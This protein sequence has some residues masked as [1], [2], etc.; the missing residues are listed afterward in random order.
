MDA[1]ELESPNLMGHSIRGWTGLES[2]DPEPR[3]GQPDENGKPDGF[4]P[5]R[6]TAKSTQIEISRYGRRTMAKIKH[7]A[8]RTPDP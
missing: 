4:G 3:A 1:L 6:L 7:I 8:I 5:L 2:G